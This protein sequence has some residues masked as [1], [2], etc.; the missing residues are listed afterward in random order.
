[1]VKCPRCG[2]KNPSSSV[3]CKNCAYRLEDSEGNRIN[4]T[5]RESSWNMG[6]GKKIVIVLCIIV[7]AFLLF[8]LVYNFTQ[9]TSK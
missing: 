1:M 4:N 3:Y 8:N 6:T 7:I 5:K 9:P 2:Y